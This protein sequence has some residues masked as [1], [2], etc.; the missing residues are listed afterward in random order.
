LVYRDVQLVWTCK[1][2]HPPIFVDIAKFGDQDGL[3]VHLADNG[4]LQVS[5]LGTEPPKLN[6]IL[7]ESKEMNYEEMDAE[8]QRLLARIMAHEQDEKVEPDLALVLG[9]Q[10][11]NVEEADEYIDDPHDIYAKGDGGRPIRMKVKV[12]L[13]YDGSELR[14]LMVH[15]NLP[16]HLEADK[17]T[18]SYKVLNFGSHTPFTETLYIYPR[19]DFFP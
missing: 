6:Y 12:S 15:V 18:F 7:P 17:V 2:S 19:N 1:T 16:K 13:S 8:H 5:Y 9:A 3:I 11:F 14:N 4:W 10:M